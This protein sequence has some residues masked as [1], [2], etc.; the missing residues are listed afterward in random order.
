MQPN[1]WQ[2]GYEHLGKGV[3]FIL[4][5]CKDTENKTS[6]LFP[7][8]LRNELREVRSTI[9]AYSNQTPLSGE[10]EADACGICYQAQSSNWNCNL[11]VTTDVGVSL[12][13]IDRWD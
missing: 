3:F 7:E 13:N 10:S 9:E 8:I 2:P 11:R 5:G 12:Y 6:A 4:K 1:L